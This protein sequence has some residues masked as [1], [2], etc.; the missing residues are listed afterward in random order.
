MTNSE[1]TTELAMAVLKHAE[2]NY[3][4][5]WDYIVECWTLA[6]IDDEIKACRTVA[7]AIKKLKYQIDLRAELYSNCF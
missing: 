5:G 6:E 4:K 7:G 1:Q 2:A 3:S